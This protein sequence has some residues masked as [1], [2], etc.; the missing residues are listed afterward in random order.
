MEDSLLE[1]IKSELEMM[2]SIYSEDNVVSKEAEDSVTH[3][4][5]VEC[6]LRLQPNTG[7]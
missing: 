7:F 2:Q 4:D 3:P 5:S 1:R 6:V